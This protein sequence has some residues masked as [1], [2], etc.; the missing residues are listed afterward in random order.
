MDVAVWVGLGVEE[1]GLGM[2]VGTVVGGMTTTVPTALDTVGGSTAV[3]F[4][5]PIANPTSATKIAHIGMR[6]GKEARAL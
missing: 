4:P 5:Q 6:C 1:V 2:R 3:E